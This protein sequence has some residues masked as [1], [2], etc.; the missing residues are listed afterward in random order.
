MSKQADVIIVGGGVIGSSIAYNL[1][2]DGFDGDIVLFEKDKTY[3][4]DATHCSAWWLGNY[5]RPELM[6]KWSNM[7][8]K[9]TLLLKKIW[10]LMM[11]WQKLIF[12]R[13]VIS[14]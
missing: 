8:L 3:E 11:N 1:L 6:W 10:L 9:N 2:N 14:F 7:L 5:L 12:N 13:M 4:Y